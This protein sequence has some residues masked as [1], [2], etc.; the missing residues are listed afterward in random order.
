VL[1][2]V[3][4]CLLNNVFIV[5]EPGATL[6][7]HSASNQIVISESFV[8][9]KHCEIS[10]PSPDNG[11]YLKD[12]GSTTGTFIMIRSEIKL[13]QGMMF[14]MGLSEFKVKSSP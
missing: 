1:K 2:A 8:S 3:E 5:G 4:G 6:G 7:R 12:V 10:S 9:R 11:F 14:Q 13:Q